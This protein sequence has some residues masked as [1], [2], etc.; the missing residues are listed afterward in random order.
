MRRHA[1]TA[2]AHLAVFAHHLGT[3]QTAL[4]PQDGR[5]VEKDPV[6]VVQLVHDRILLLPMCCHGQF[7]AELCYA[8]LALLAVGL[9]IVHS[10][11]ETLQELVC[12]GVLGF[13]DNVSHGVARNFCCSLGVCQSGRNAYCEDDD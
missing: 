9:V 10:L 6:F 3:V 5:V 8:L 11:V 1:A 12:R 7:G 4:L 2:L 13:F